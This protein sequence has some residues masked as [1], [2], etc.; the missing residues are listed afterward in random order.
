MFGG[1]D[2]E[3]GYLESAKSSGKPETVIGPS[4]RVDGNLRGD[5]DI[6]VEGEVKGSIKTKQQLRVGPGAKVKA[7]IDAGSAQI[8]GQVSG[9]M[10]IKSELKASSSAQI[11]G[12]IEVKVLEVA[13]GASLNGH[14]KMEGDNAIEPD[15]PDIEVP[16]VVKEK[17]IKRASKPKKKE[18]K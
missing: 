10:K 3:N 18:A 7:S 9:N 1:K 2:E 12:D 8:A 14:I 6:V 17:T 15:S 4:V 13:A 11:H 5:G 16:D